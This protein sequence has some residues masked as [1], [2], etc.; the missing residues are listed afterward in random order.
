VFWSLSSAERVVHAK[1]AG[2]HGVFEATE[3]NSDLCCAD[4][5][6]FSLPC[7]SIRSLHSDDYAELTC[8]ASL[9]RL[10]FISSSRRA[11]SLLPSLGSL[12]LEERA[13]RQI[14]YVVTF[15]S[16]PPL[17]AVF[18]TSPVLLLSQARDPRGF[19]VKVKTTEGNWDFVGNNTPIFFLRDPAKF[20]LFIH[21]QKRNP[22]TNLKDPEA[23]W[24]YLSQNP[25]SVHQV[26]ILFGERGAF[27]SDS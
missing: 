9:L 7:E 15:P 19:S 18:L 6:S 25:E 4:V 13:G 14:P 12:L 11:P 8:P 2:A 27:L 22:Q 16:S 17:L 1:G 26:L 3:D 23:F 5:C 24:G 21:T 10:P 20:P